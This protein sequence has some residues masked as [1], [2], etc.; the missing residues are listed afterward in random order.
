M[1]GVMIK[2]NLVEQ[3]NLHQSKLDLGKTSW[4][5]GQIHQATIKNAYMKLI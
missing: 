5:K 3:L 4:C 2:L 1:P